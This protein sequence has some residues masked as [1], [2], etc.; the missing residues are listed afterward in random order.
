MSASAPADVLRKGKPFVYR[1]LAPE[2]DMDENRHISNVAYVRWLQDAARAHSDAIGWTR[3]RYLAEGGFFGVRRHAVDYLRPASAGD[4][5]QVTTWIQDPRPASAT[6]ISE[7]LRT[8]DNV[9]LARAQTTWVWL[10]V[11][12]GRPLKLPPAITESFC[13]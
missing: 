7:I 2:T 9:V 4:P 8:S 11:D 10:S 12:G 1:F 3:E 13:S 5:I 6:R